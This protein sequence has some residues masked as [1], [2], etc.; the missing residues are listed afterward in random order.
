MKIAV[1]GANGQL[2]SDAVTAFQ[3]NG[4]EV[5][6]LTHSDVELQD[7]GSVSSCLKGI[8]PQVVVN[9]VA[10]EGIRAIAEWV[11]GHGAR[12]SRV[13]RISK[14]VKRCRADRVQL[15]DQKLVSES[16]VPDPSI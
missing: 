9:T 3:G 6:A 12:E 10:M 13:F 1:I 11:I 15:P 2:G 4:D 8:R 16:F 7:I 5:A 14:S